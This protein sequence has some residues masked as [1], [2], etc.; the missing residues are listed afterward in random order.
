ML[1]YYL[2]FDLLF[3][4]TREY[5]GGGWVR[6]ARGLGPDPNLG[7]QAKGLWPDLNSGLW[8]RDQGPDPN[9]GP[10]DFTLW[11]CSYY[12]NHIEK[13]LPRPSSEYLRNRSRSNVTCYLCCRINWWY[14]YSLL[15][16]KTHLMIRTHFQK[17]CLEFHKKLIAFCHSTGHS[18]WPETWYLAELWMISNLENAGSCVCQNFWNW[19]CWRVGNLGNLSF[20][21]VANVG[22]LKLRDFEIL[23]LWDFWNRFGK[24]GDR[25][26][27]KIRIIIF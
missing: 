23:K 3:G 20:W 4:S 26:I 18:S 22:T 21:N 9:S 2:L 5:Q 24:G 12:S 10:S 25:Q 27:M 6:V 13:D 17:R 15:I 14:K 11:L 1:Y 8:D 7:L 19:K 16:H